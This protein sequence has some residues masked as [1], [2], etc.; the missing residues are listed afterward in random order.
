MAGALF[1]KA[2]LAVISILYS[3]PNESYYLR[4]LAREAGVGLGAVQRET[5]HLASAGVITRKEKDSQVYFQANKECQVFNELRSLV[6]KTSGIGDVLRAS[7]KGLGDSIKF[8]FVY[9]SIAR[10][11]DRAGSDIDLLVVGDVDFKKV[12]SELVQA[13]KILGRE[14]NP[15]VFPP[16]EFR[17]KVKAG[18]HFLSTVLK[19]KKVFIKGDELGLERL[20][21]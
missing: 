12:N 4:R 1:G 10:G 8:A 13:Q 14:V 9:G 18:N 6:I 3:S 15:T 19:D 21:E 20:A 17:K 2:R 11:N 16:A 7:I 5:M